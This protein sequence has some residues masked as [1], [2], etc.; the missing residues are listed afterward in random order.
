LLTAEQQGRR[1]EGTATRTPPVWYHRYSV[2]TDKEGFPVKYLEPETYRRKTF[3]GPFNDP[4]EA[5]QEFQ[6]RIGKDASCYLDNKQFQAKARALA[7]LRRNTA[8]HREVI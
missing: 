8:K 5:S 7:A 1:D 2:L 3:P 4:G 6:A